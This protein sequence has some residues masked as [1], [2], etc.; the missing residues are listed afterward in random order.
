MILL[1]VES[2]WFK[3]VTNADFFNIEKAP[4][5]TQ[6][7]GGMTYFD[8]PKTARDALF[9]FL[10]FEVPPPTGPF[11]AIHLP[12]VRAIG[13][14]DRA[15][16]LS[17]S[18]NRDND[19]RYRIENQNRHMPGSQRHPAWTPELGF[20]QATSPVT[21]AASAEPF[22][23]NGLRIFLVR[24]TN[25][26]IYAGFIEGHA[27]PPDWP[28]PLEAM[29]TSS[30]PGGDIAVGTPG[31]FDID[32]V[33]RRVLDAWGRGRFNVLLYGPP[34]TGKTHA[35]NSLRVLLNSGIGPS[36]VFL[37]PQDRARPFKTGS[38]VLPISLPVVQDWVTFHQ[39]YSYEDF[40]VGLRPQPTPHGVSLVPRVGR[41]LDLAIRVD[42]DGVGSAVLMVDEIN[43]GNVARIFGEFITFMDPDYRAAA[44]GSAKNPLQL[45]VPLP[46][47]GVSGAH[48]QP[49]ERPSG[50][51]V[52][53]PVPWYFPRSFYMV[54]SMNSVDRAVA[55]LDSALGRRF[56]RIEVGP[57]FEL[58]A[59]W[60]GITSTDIETKLAS[61]A[62]P[63]GSTLSAGEA[64]WLLLNR[65]NHSIATSLGPEFELGHTYL[66]GVASLAG[67]DERFLGLATVW[68]RALLPQLVDR[69]VGRPAELL[70]LLKVDA[71]DR[72]PEYL[73]AARTFPFGSTEDE[74]VALNP[75]SLVER[76]ADAPDAVRA[77]LRFLAVP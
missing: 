43:R 36:A 21:D 30:D 41:M 32:D 50:G 19:P 45:P 38:D 56:E 17:M 6:G 51:A 61:G 31:G 34:G 64:G 76:W 72:P 44:P 23:R 67:E 10:G 77:T 60:L 68:E 4:G 54:A 40:I 71:D 75:V 22:L 11:P 37:D 52:R 14:P 65:L 42:V 53:L 59:E 24:T 73:F 47:V 7:G 8:I 35:M 1:P 39:S 15:A 74:G 70:R 26:K 58:L 48:T 13:A 29:F 5:T 63:P 9:R 18:K 69:F 62:M 33:V 16:Q 12:D 55:P 20:P 3:R 57:D 28:P 27:P 2:I 66:R 46:S 25:D 49:L